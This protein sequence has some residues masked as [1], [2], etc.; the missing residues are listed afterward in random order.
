MD[1]LYKEFRQT[2]EAFKAAVDRHDEELKKTGA[3]S[4]ETKALVDTLNNKITELDNQI[5]A[6][7]AEAEALKARLDE[8]EAAQKRI[9]ANPSNDPRQS[10]AYK[11]FMSY[12]K[13]GK[14]NMGP[15]AI[16]ALVEDTEGRVL[17]PEI[18]EAEIY[19]ELPPLTVMYNLVTVRK[20][21]KGDRLRRRSINGVTVSWGKLETGATLTENTF[22]PQLSDYQYVEDLYGLAKVGEDEL[23]DSEVNIEALLN[24]AFTDAFAAAIDNAIMVGKGHTSEEPEGLLLGSTLTRVTGSTAKAIKYDDVLDLVYAVDPRYRNN[25]VFICHSNTELQLRKIKDG[26]GRYL[27]MPTVAVG[28]PN[29]FLGYKLYNQSQVPYVTS[30]MTEAADVLL[31]GDFKACYR[32]IERQGLQLKRLNELYAE[33]GMIGLR[34]NMRVG[35][36]VIRPAAVKVLQVPAS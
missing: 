30:T 4:A 31:F 14:P 28:M 21:A 25:A 11:A 6:K 36:G 34:L 5:K 12:L 20:L 2:V 15:D 22:T 19:K 27:W 26:E 18:I 13:L 16:K 35:G 24:E 23:A 8:L 29:T 3:V 32:W 10:D 33:D 1:E 17:L 7:F 9:N